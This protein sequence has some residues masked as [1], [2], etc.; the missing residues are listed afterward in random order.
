MSMEE[1]KKALDAQNVAFEEFKK[2]NNERIENIKKDK[3]V[4]E[5][6]TKIAKIEE[7]ISKATDEYK[8]RLDQYEA[9]MKRKGTGEDGERISEEMQTYK[10]A[11]QN[12]LRKCQ[13]TYNGADIRAL[14]TKA[15]S[16][17]SEPD[18]GYTVHPDLTGRIA[19]KVFETSPIRQVASV[20]SISTDALEGIVDFDEPGSGWEGEEDAPA[21]SDTPQIKK[22]R[23]PTHELRAK[24]KVTQKLLEDSSFDIEMWLGDHVARKFARDENYAFVQ[25]NGVG[26]PRG[27]MTYAD[28]TAYG[29]IE[30]VDSGIAYAPATRGV[31]FDTIID[32][33]Y[34][35][36]AEY[37][38]NA[39]FVGSRLGMAALR[40]LTDDEGQYLWQPAVQAGQP[41]NV[42]GIPVLEFE[43]LADPTAD[44][45]LPYAVGDF[46]RGYQ[47][48]DRIGMSVLRDPFSSKPYVEYYFR[49]RCGGDV[50][51]FEAIK[52]YEIGV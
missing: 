18:G 4:G 44:G 24:P 46:S 11:V 23:I 40:R 1:V 43:D 48:V 28:G 9:A 7:D 38:A 26:R 39:N 8:K 29:Q 19:K 30:R 49:T 16:V 14:A 6:E 12:Y 47:I 45:D 17:N 15:M 50:I 22:W 2:A 41:A 52:I 25:G 20:Q 21:N 35:L 42:F 33:I 3:S 31:A 27:F 34:Q 51:N 36:K 10:A 5:L 37:R 13:D 32:L